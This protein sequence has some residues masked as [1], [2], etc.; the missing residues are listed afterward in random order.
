MVTRQ[1]PDRSET[2]A[3]H[4]HDREIIKNCNEMLKLHDLGEIET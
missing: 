4:R 3:R 2:E 1:M